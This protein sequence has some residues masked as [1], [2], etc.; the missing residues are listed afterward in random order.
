MDEKHLINAARYIEMNPVRAG[1]ALQPGDYPYSS[2]NAH[3][4]GKDDKLVTV[5][6]L[7]K[8][9]GDWSAFLLTSTDKREL[10]EFRLHERTGRPLGS[11]Q[12]VNGIEELTG[13]VLRKQRPGPKRRV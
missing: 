6:S 12:F 7:L 10:K 9:A 5:A 8:I 3:L 13:R 4:S 2:A 11:E 1:L